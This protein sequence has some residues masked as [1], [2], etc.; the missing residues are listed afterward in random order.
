MHSQGG[1][2]QEEIDDL[3]GSLNERQRRSALRKF[4]RGE[5]EGKRGT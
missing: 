4:E 5:A 3:L 2:T 1:V